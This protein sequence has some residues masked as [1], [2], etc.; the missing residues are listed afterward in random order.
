MATWYRTLDTLFSGLTALIVALFLVSLVG[1]PFFGFSFPIQGLIER[2]LQILF[3]I[4]TCF[5]IMD[6]VRKSVVREPMRIAEIVRLI[7]ILLLV[8]AVIYSAFFSPPG[9]APTVL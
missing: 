8:A 9:A 7:C 2:I 5:V 4:T 3:W 1:N 6:V